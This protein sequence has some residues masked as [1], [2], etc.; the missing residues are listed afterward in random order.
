MATKNGIVKKTRLSEFMNIRKSGIQAIS[1]RDDDVLIGVKLTDGK[2]D[3]MLITENGMCIRFNE[4]DVRFTGRSSMGVIGMTLTDDNVI[5]MILTNEGSNILFVSE[6]GLG[7]LTA[8]DEFTAQHRGGKGVKCYKL[9]ERSGVLVAAKAVDT[10]GEVM[11]ITTEGV[12]IRIPI[13]GI[14]ILG[15][16]TTGVKLINLDKGNKVA[17]VTKVLKD[18]E[19]EELVDE[20]LE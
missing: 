4:N 15:R 6:N 11:L 10:E 14:S 5:E 19:V 7:K 3:A 16:N 17:G 13:D 12:V 20:A 1:L 8:M 18:D 9:M 2:S